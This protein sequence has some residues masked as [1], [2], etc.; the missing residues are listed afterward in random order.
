MTGSWREATFRASR[1]FELR[2]LEELTPSER[3]SLRELEED[4]D[5]AG[6]LVPCV[7]GTA[8][9]KSVTRDGAAL[10]RSLATPSRLESA[11]LDD[12]IADL[13]LDGVLEMEA[14]GEFVWGADALPFLVC[15]TAGQ[16]DPRCIGRLSVDAMR[17]AADL[18]SADPATL[19]TALY[20]YHRIPLSP[21][22]RSR[23]AGPESVLAYLGAGQGSLASLLDAEWQMMLPSP[24][25]LGWIAWHA[26][27]PR[28][29]VD[30]AMYKL[31]V[32]PRP[33]NIREAFEAV[34]HHFAEVGGIDFKIGADAHG[35]LRPDKFVAYFPSYDELNRVAVALR[36]RLGGIPAHGVPFTAAVD[37][38]GLLSWGV[39]PPAHARALRWLGRESWRLWLATKLGNALAAAKISSSRRSVEPWKFA[40]ERV[41]RLG[42]NVEQWTPAEDFWREA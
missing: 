42:V 27:G 40:L 3:E 20:L 4:V 16:A 35:L 26:R 7:T 8:D 32:S 28:R 14:G 2:R 22:W 18:E 19:A 6:L 31:Y 5:F 1:R 9:V 39:D 24:H 21:F 29:A 23:F 10:F 41:R 17:H 34:V 15:A 25:S 13:V 12:E 11:L 37:D 36:K 33:E 38:D 30:G